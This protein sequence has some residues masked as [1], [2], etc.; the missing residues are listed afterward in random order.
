[1]RKILFILAMLT[2]S[3]TLLTACGNSENKK[4]YH[5][6]NGGG[7]YE[8]TYFGPVPN[9]LG[10]YKTGQVDLVFSEYDKDNNYVGGQGMPDARFG[11]TE[12]FRAEKNAVKIIVQAK[13]DGDVHYPSTG[14]HRTYSNGAYYYSQVYELD[15]SDPIT[16]TIREDDQTQ[17]FNPLGVEIE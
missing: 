16:F 1:M 4:K 6:T 7:I 8:V 11:H 5:V 9:G 14:E 3:A 15:S 13:V 2:A 12:L 17:V 10:D